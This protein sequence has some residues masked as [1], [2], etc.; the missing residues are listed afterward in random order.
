MVCF[1]G[2][3]SVFGFSCLCL[4]WIWGGSRVSRVGLGDLSVCLSV[5]VSRFSYLQG[6][7][8]GIEMGDAVQAMRDRG[9]D[10]P[11]REEVSVLWSI[12]GGSRVGYERVFVFL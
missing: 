7:G 4:G 5:C 3:S 6:T 2:V 8:K 10:L 11:R 12:L 9:F 1:L